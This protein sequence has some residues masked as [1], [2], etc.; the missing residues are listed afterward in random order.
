MFFYTRRPR[1]TLV[2]FLIRH[3]LRLSPVAT[4]PSSIKN[5]G[6]LTKED[7]DIVSDLIFAE[8]VKGKVIARPVH[9]LGWPNQE[10]V[11]GRI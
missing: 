11:R 1:G 7:A 8:V 9:M 6:Y 10:W 2:T 3:L 4:V 5:K